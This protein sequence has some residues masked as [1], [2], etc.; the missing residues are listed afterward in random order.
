MIPFPNT[1][2]GSVAKLD[3]VAA[4]LF[5][6]KIN[7]LVRRCICVLIVAASVARR[8]EGGGGFS[9]P[10]VAPCGANQI[11]LPS[12][13]AAKGEDLRRMSRTTTTHAYHLPVQNPACAGAG[14]AGGGVS[15]PAKEQT[16]FATP[17][18]LGTE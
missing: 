6:L 11:P 4:L 8:R 15:T 1:K 5:H 7:Q 12:Q 16:G 14:G 17:P 2:K 13:K 10:A 3:V 18:L 9:S